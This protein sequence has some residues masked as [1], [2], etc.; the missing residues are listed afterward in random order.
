MSGEA[1]RTLQREVVYRQGKWLTVEEHTVALPDG[2]RIENWSWVDTPDF[3]NVA[4][5]T[6]DGQFVLF[7]QRKYAIDGVSLAPVGG[8][9]EPGEE[10]LVAA[11]REVLEETGYEALRW[12]PLGTYR[13]DANRGAGQAH[14][15]L[16]LDAYAV[17][18]P[19]AD[20]LE[21]QQLLLLSGDEVR[22]AVQRGEFMVLPWAALMALALLHLDG[23]TCEND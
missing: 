4:L 20:D 21:E 23:A 19:D 7:R 15:F 6:R 14:L 1:W 8:Y 10:P 2:R 18:E 12:V 17:T 13:V 16:A 11:K 5:I 9:I 22:A 3:V